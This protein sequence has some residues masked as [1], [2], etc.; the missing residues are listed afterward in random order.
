M[1]NTINIIGKLLNL[2]DPLIMGIINV[3]PDSFYK[4][5]RYNPFQEDFL[6][7]AGQMI[8]NG[9]GILDIGGYST[10]PGAE[11]VNINEE[12]KRV[13]KAIDI[14]HSNFPEIPISI[15]T[16]R[17]EV[18]REAI[19]A[20]AS[21]VNDVS[22]G[23]LDEKMFDFIISKNLP[24]ILMH[25]RGNPQNMASMTTYGEL[26]SEILSELF[27]K[28]N[29]LRKSGV[30]D[31]IIDPGFGF[32]KNQQQNFQ[33]LQHLE[34][35][36]NENYPVLIGISRK[37]MIYK[38]LNITAEETLNSTSALHMLALIKK[39]KILRVHDVKEAF[40][41]KKLFKNLF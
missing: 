16:F 28:A 39:T 22:G 32:A 11:E 25:S 6:E 9:A 10:R 27:S 40:Q 31:I 20:G 35:F 41:V 12:I 33:L 3:T 36:Q 30:K 5:S 4:D 14:I 1:K 13:T 38:L 7:K 8:A 17:S 24:Y 2:E 34:I 23:A 29:Q 19:D 21:I 18:A 15:D 26:Y 37:S